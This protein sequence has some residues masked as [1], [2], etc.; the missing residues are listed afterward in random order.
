MRAP[1][2]SRWA[3]R[4]SL[5]QFGDLRDLSSYLCGTLISIQV[6]AEDHETSSNENRAEQDECPNQAQLGLK[7]I[8]DLAWA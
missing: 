8:V 7:G 3:K 6:T 1:G 5:F 2:V 4:F